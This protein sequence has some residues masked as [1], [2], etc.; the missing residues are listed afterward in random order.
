MTRVSE[1]SSQANPQPLFTFNC[2]DLTNWLDQKESSKAAPVCKTTDQPET[3]HSIAT[4]Q[5]TL[6]AKINRLLNLKNL[7]LVENTLKMA[8]FDLM[9]LGSEK[10][11]KTIVQDLNNKQLTW[12]EVKKQST[13]LLDCCLKTV[14]FCKKF[15]LQT[16]LI[17]SLVT[18]IGFGIDFPPVAVIGLLAIPP[19]LCLGAVFTVIS[20]IGHWYER[21][22]LQGHLN[23]HLCTTYK[24]AFT[25]LKTWNDNI[26]IVED[27]LLQFEKKLT[28]QIGNLTYNDSSS[29]EIPDLI[30]LLKCI[31]DLINNLSVQKEVKRLAEAEM[32]DKGIKISLFA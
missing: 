7:T 2:Q 8:E 22:T 31:Q 17:S 5:E 32:V 20:K 1:R 29:E 9:S 28:E 12:K 21:K 26:G 25:N 23:Q 30:N 19:S 16:L 15:F 18:L 10:S 6:A 13:S 27:Y 24:D 4:C 11:I 14:N 3:S